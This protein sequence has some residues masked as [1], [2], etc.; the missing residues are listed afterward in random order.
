MCT[1]VIDEDR[2]SS[3]QR[4]TGMRSAEV[5]VCKALELKEQRSGRIDG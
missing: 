3:P 2:N 1:S 4:E 5:D